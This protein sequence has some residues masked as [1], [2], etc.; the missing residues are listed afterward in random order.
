ML[1]IKYF[2]MMT[3]QLSCVQWQK[4]VDEEMKCVWPEH[5]YHSEI[6]VTRNREY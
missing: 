1:E 3:R 5:K 6:A 2:T 4:M